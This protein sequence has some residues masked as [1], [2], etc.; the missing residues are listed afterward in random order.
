MVCPSDGH[1]VVTATWELEKQP[2]HEFLTNMVNDY[3]GH[4]I[5]FKKPIDGSPLFVYGVLTGNSTRMNKTD[6]K[7]Q[8]TSTTVANRSHHHMFSLEYTLNFTLSM[9]SYPLKD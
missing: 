9:D 6:K 8:S 5:H 1:I 4:I 7:K 3:W 2:T